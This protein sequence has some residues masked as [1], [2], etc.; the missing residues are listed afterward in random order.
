LRTINDIPYR[1]FTEAARIHDIIL[2]REHEGSMAMM[3]ARDLRRPPNDLR[4]I[5]AL[6]IGSGAGWQRLF[7]ESKDVMRGDGDTD[8]SIR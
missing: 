8:D 4:L 5:F 1:T 6:G 2:D 3:L 7:D